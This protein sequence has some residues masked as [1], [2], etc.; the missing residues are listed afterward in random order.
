MRQGGI[1][2]QDTRYLLDD[3]VVANR[4]ENANFVNGILSLSL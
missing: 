2:Q 4:G 1:K 3:H